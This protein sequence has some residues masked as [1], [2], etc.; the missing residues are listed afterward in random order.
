MDALEAVRVV[1]AQ[2]NNRTLKDEAHTVV[3]PN[4]VHITIPTARQLNGLDAFIQN[5]LG[6]IAAF[7]DVHF[8]TIAE[9]VNGGGSA[10]VT[11]R[12]TGTFTGQLEMPDGPV[13]GNGNTIDFQSRVEVV[14]EEGKI[15]RWTVDYNLGEFL[16]QLGLG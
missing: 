16:H 15:I 12:A 5:S 4:V 1:N 7:P 9:K 14:V 6:F 2:F 11:Y 10:V 13:M 3:S 8:E